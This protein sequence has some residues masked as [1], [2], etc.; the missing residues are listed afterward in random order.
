MKTSL[1][2][3]AQICH[4]S[5]GT[6]RLLRW[7]ALVVGALVALGL[8]TGCAAFSVSATY[9]FGAGRKA[10]VTLEKPAGLAK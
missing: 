6:I 2:H 3:P 7:G 1:L 5:R 8:L 9:E 10:S 4:F